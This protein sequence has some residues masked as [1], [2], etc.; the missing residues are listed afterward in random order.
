AIVGRVRCRRVRGQGARWDPRAPSPLP[1]LSV[2]GRAKRGGAARRGEGALG[3]RRSALDAVPVAFSSS[4]ATPRLHT[5]IRS[6]GGDA[7]RPR[8]ADRTM[9]WLSHAAV[10]AHSRGAIDGSKKP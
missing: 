5:A 2:P 7:W 8:V 10:S 6:G 9:R 4:A 3:S 1:P